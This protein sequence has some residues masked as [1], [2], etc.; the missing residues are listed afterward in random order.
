MP[1][2]SCRAIIAV[3]DPHF[4][5]GGGGGGVYLLA[6]LDFLPFVISS[7][8]TQNNG[9]PPLDPPLNSLNFQVILTR[10]YVSAI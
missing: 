5:V 10:D 1:C 9:E 2:S 8:F 4:E 6:L 3:T 7:F